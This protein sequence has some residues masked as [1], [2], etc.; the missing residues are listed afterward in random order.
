M[1]LRQQMNHTTTD[2]SS[3]DQRLAAAGIPFNTVGENTAMAGG[4]SIGDAVTFLDTNMMAEPMV[5]GGHR[6]N[7]VYAGYNTVGIGIVAAGGQ[8]WLTEDFVG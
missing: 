4:Q 1:F 2:D 5:E 3:P 8:V 6:W 7:I